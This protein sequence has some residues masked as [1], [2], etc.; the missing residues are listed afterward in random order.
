MKLT[1]SHK[2]IKNTSTYGLILREYLLNTG[3]RHPNSERARKSPWNRKGQK[4][5]KEIGKGLHPRSPFTAGEIS[6][7]R[8]GP[9]EL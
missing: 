9:S 6:Q 2:F 3:K 1:S 4:K 7:D 8:G 5:K